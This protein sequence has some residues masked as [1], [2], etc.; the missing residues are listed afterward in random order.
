M[1]AARKFESSD[2]DLECFVEAYSYD[3]NRGWLNNTYVWRQDSIPMHDFYSR[4]A[5]GLITR[6]ARH[7]NPS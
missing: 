7:S 2:T 5:K 1:N 4:N 3:A 6:I